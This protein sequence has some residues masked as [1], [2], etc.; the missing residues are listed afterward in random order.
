MYEKILSNLTDFKIFICVLFLDVIGVFAF[1]NKYLF[2]DVTFLK[3]LVVVMVLDLI[4]GITKV[5][6]NEGAKAITSKGLRCSVSKVIQYS[7]FLIVT[8]VLTH[9]QIGDQTNTDFTFLSKMAYEFL[10]LIEIKSVYENIIR[11]NPSLDVVTF[12]SNKIV[13]ALKK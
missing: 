13:S 11:I 10:I 5:W 6:I 4:T 3:W 2:S 12:V 8:H 7:A 9:F 1:I